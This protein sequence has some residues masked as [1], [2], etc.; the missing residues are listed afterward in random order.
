MRKYIFN[1]LNPEDDGLFELVYLLKSGSI[2]SLSIFV[3]TNEKFMSNFP[4]FT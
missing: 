2:N 3:G 4:L 1:N